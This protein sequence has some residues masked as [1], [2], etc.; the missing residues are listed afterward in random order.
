MKTAEIIT[1]TMT[2][3]RLLFPLVAM[4]LL[5][6]GTFVL[7]MTHRLIDS[8]IPDTIGYVQASHQ[9]ARGE[10]LAFVDPNNQI[11]ERYYTL[12]AFKVV[13]ADDRNRY[14]GYLPGVPLLAA[15]VERVTGDPEAVHAVQP[16]MAAVL[17]AFTYLFGAL[18]IDHWTGLWASL[19]LAVAP[20]LL[21]FST[22]LWSEVPS[23]VFLYLGCILALLALRRIQDDH[24]AAWLAVGGG[25][26][27]GVTFFMRFSNVTCIPMIV[28]LA[29][30]VGGR[31]IFRQRRVWLLIG[32]IGISLLALLI[33]NTVY[34]G[35][36]LDT[37]YS[38]IHGWYDQPAFSLSY[39]FGSS[40]VGGYSVPAIINEFIVN[41]G[42][43]LLFVLV[44]LITQPRWHGAW[45]L[46]LVFFMLL[47]YATYAFAPQGPNARFIIPALPAVCLL[48]GR[49]IM[50]IGVRL[51][52]KSIRLAFGV[53]LT[54][55]M[56]YKLP[57][58]LAA[59]DQVNQ[60]AHAQV[61]YVQQLISSTEPNAVVMSY[62]FND[63]I[64]VYGHRSVLN[65]RHMVPYDLV[66]GH[67][68][69]SQFE[70]V[71]ITEVNRLLSQGIPVYYLLDSDPALYDS[72]SILGRHFRL[73]P[74]I[75]GGSLYKVIQ[76]TGS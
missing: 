61:K 21:G 12:Y 31:S 73:L 45:L 72:Y 75:N 70:G 16:M 65:Y 3:K 55:G 36:P 17:V 57:A 49:G 40:F 48:I 18:L 38:P 27:I 19:A 32:S 26:S 29:G 9:L 46:G 43:L 47:P 71:L 25:L 51:S 6:T 39:A 13:H 68:Q 37:G 35:G 44:G 11:N 8:N 69:Y 14:F 33:F 41:F 5:V 76:L 62:V 22:A 52:N 53:L 59:L 58:N 2:I 7:A 23:A 54:I 20:I 63:L 4:T 10:G 60:S 66:S 30:L 28:A 74:V 24:R 64:A 1:R 15:A 56:L 34:Y 67:Y 50:S 42:G